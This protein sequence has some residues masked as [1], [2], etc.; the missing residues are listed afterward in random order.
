ME[1]SLRSENFV[2]GA[3]QPLPALAHCGVPMMVNST[4][5]PLLA[6]NVTA[7]SYVDQL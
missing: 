3:F 7:R 5:I 4:F 1:N 6:A 2:G